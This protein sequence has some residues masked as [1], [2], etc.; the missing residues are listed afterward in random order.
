MTGPRNYVAN[1]DAPHD[2]LKAARIAARFDTA[3]EFAER[4][5]VQA[6][7]YG[8]HERGAPVH[9]GTG[10]GLTRRTA[11]RYADLLGRYLAPVTADWLLLGRGEPPVGVLDVVAEMESGEL[12][13]SDGLTERRPGGRDSHPSER[14]GSKHRVYRSDA[15]SNVMPGR[16]SPQ[17]PFGGAAVAVE[18]GAFAA[19]VEATDRYLEKHRIAVDPSRKGELYLVLYRRVSEGVEIAD[20][21]SVIRSFSEK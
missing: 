18:T 3:R 7:T 14:L 21:H 8:H 6:A 17:T 11:G 5:G 9:G 2:R 12:G 1:L 10:R 15:D 20:N 16:G 19:V 4:H 13:I